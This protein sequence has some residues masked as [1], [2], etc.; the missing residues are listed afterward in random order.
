MGSASNFF[1]RDCPGVVSS[2]HQ[3]RVATRTFTLPG[4]LLK[5][6]ANVIG[7]CVGEIKDVRRNCMRLF[8]SELWAVN[9]EIEAW[10][11]YPSLYSYCVL[12]VILHSQ[13]DNDADLLKWVILKSTPYGV[14]IDQPLG[15]HILV[16]FRLCSKAIWNEA[17]G[18]AEVVADRGSEG[19]EVELTV[20]A[21]SFRCPILIE[22][23]SWFASELAVLYGEANA[24]LFTGYLLKQCLFK[25]ASDLML[26]SSERYDVGCPNISEISQAAD[27]DHKSDEFVG[28]NKQ[29]IMD[30]VVRRDVYVSQVAAAVAALQERSLLEWKIKTRQFSQPYSTYQR[31]CAH[32]DFSKKAHE[33]RQNRSDYRPILEHDGLC[34]NRSNDKETNK[35]KTKEELLAEERDYKRRRMSYRGK[36]SKRTTTEVMRDIIDDHMEEIKQAGGI[37]CFVRGTEKVGLSS[38]KFLSHN[39]ISGAIEAEESAFGLSKASAGLSDYRRQPQTDYHINYPRFQDV[40]HKDFGDWERNTYGHDQHLEKKRIDK[41]RRD[42]GYTAESPEQ[43]RSHGRLH[44]LVG[45][46]GEQKYVENTRSKHYE[47]N[48]RSSNQR[49]GRSRSYSKSNSSLGKHNSGMEKHNHE[50]DTRD[51]HW[52]NICKPRRSDSASQYSI[53]DRYDPSDPHDMYLDDAVNGK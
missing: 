45:H 44:E 15:D 6:C 33:E 19:K 22:V 24:K 7:G 25:S 9:R 27:G 46:Q 4:V 50:S 53:D 41:D 31:M 34:W 18:L 8:P 14:V 49:D 35:T 10:N 40:S 3:D 42:R 39:V 28:K 21:M 23:L 30:E 52:G 26:F 47:M 5:E 36:K 13:M 48:Q 37:G 38:G 16:L 32:A 43:H 51:R 29:V 11:D 12:Q 17:I 2:V 1:Y 20:K